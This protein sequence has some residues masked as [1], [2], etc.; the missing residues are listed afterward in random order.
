MG[1]K[2]LVED[3][4]DAGLASATAGCDTGA[5]LQLLERS[6]AFLDGLAQA[7]L[8]NTVTDADVH[9]LTLGANPSVATIALQIIRI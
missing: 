5:G 3:L 4:A 1:I 2:G 9:G 6:S 8:G 7:L